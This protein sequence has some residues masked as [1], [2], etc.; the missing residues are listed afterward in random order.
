MQIVFNDVF[1]CIV[2]DENSESESDTEEKLKGGLWIFF[3]TDMLDAC[4]FFIRLYD[5]LEV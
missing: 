3:G 1:L 4:L 2:T 5:L